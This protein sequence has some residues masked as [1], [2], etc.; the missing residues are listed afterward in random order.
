MTEIHLKV[1]G[2]VTSVDVEP[3]V[4]LLDLLRERLELTGAKKGCDQGA[5]G[6]CTVLANGQRINACLALAVSYDGSEITTIE[7][8]AHP[9]Q[10]AFIR[11][12][13][14]WSLQR[15]RGGSTRH[16]DGSARPDRACAACR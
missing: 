13:G 10:E 12:D 8:V 15:G 16:R 3:R 6:A 5:C 4:S 1:N 7:G 9:L 11:H 14:F 2:F